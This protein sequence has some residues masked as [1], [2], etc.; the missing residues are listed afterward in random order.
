MIKHLKSGMRHQRTYRNFTHWALHIWD[1]RNYDVFQ[2]IPDQCSQ[3]RVALSL[4]SIG[5]VQFLAETSYVK[6]P[7]RGQHSSNHILH[8]IFT[9]F[10]TSWGTCHQPDEHADAVCW[11]VAA[12]VSNV[13]NCDIQLPGMLL[14]WKVSEV[15]NIRYTNEWLNC[16]S[17][18]KLILCIHLWN[19]CLH[20]AVYFLTF[21]I[22]R[23]HWFIIE[24]G[25]K[26]EMCQIE[27]CTFQNILVV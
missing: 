22:C 6:I 8:C 3:K 7:E 19:A 18:R 13:T 15:T 24:M 20:L 12:I 4:K 1:L 11:H 16:H 10:S 14:P 5:T 26:W 25:L 23:V 27:L 17:G 9:F 21:W 2:I